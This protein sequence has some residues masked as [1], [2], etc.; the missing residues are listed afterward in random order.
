MFCWIGGAIVG[1]V[2]LAFGVVSFLRWRQAKMLREIALNE[3]ARR[4][5]PPTPVEAPTSERDLLTWQAILRAAQ[6]GMW[7]PSLEDTGS[8]ESERELRGGA[9]SDLFRWHG[10]LAHPERDV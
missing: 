9:S 2:V 3:A 4:R 6:S 5:S 10:C 7:K 1:S 8:R